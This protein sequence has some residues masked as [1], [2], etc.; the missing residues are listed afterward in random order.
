MHQTAGAIVPR[1][2]PS[3]GDPERQ[4]AQEGRVS[5]LDYRRYYDLETFL[6]GDVS[7]R[8]HAEGSIGA[9]D[10]FSIVISP[11]APLSALP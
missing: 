7:P 11:L 4:A 9:F 5:E 6:F 8:F 3:A 2:A 1:I 10:F